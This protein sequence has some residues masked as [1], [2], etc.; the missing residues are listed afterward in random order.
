MHG[1][2]ADEFAVSGAFPGDEAVDALHLMGGGGG[3]KDHRAADPGLFVFREKIR[4]GAEAVGQILG[5]QQLLVVGVGVKPPGSLN[6][7]FGDLVRENMHMGVDDL[8][9][10]YLGMENTIKNLSRRP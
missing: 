8:H 6:G 4:H 2:H 7:R 5:G 10:L 1:A 9:L 3:G